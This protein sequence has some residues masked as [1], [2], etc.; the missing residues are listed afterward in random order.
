MRIEEPPTHIDTDDAAETELKSQ[1]HIQIDR[2]GL[3]QQRHANDV[4]SLCKAPGV[5]NKND[6]SS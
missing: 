3:D 5:L 2:V 4:D 1:R 6:R